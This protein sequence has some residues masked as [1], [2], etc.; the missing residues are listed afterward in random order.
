MP[1]CIRKYISLTV[2]LLMIFGVGQAYAASGIQ[3]SVEDYQAPD[4]VL[5]DQ[6]GDEVSFKE[7]V[8]QDHPVLLDFIYTTCTT[9]C[10]VLSAGYSH[11]LR[12][13]GDHSETVQLISVSI[14]PEYDRPQL[15]KE[16]LERYQSRK[17]WS[18]LTGS[19]QDIDTVMHS[20]DAYVSNKMSHYPLTL[21]KV[22]GKDQWVRLYGLVGTK[23]LISE[24]E[25]LY[26]PLQQVKGKP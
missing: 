5:V 16:Y 25:Q 24:I 13:L 18:Y 21:I 11:L 7:L 10:P 26:G 6:N 17:G 20:F 8:N 23:K 1:T 19:R 9:I 12:R 2:L 4:V 14:D 22:P 3:R 15:M